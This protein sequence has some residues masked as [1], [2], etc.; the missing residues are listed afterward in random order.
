MM[1]DVSHC[2][3]FIKKMSSELEKLSDTGLWLVVV[4]EPAL[5]PAFGEELRVLPPH[6]LH[7]V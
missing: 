2:Y 5:L 7:S 4:G 1:K 3:I 6:T